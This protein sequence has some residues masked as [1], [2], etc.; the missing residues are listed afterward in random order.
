MALSELPIFMAAVR[1]SQ[2]GSY[3][4]NYGLTSGGRFGAY[5]ISGT[6]WTRWSQAV[7]LGGAE[8]RSRTAQDAVARAKM[9]QLYNR[10]TDWRLVMV[11]WL[12]GTKAADA[13]RSK[14]LGAYA[15]EAKRL[16]S[17]MRAARDQGF[18]GRAPDPSLVSQLD[19]TARDSIERGALSID[20]DYEPDL[21]VT[22]SSARPLGYTP[23]SSSPGIPSP[24]SGTELAK[25][26]TASAPEPPNP[27][28]RRRL[29]SSQMH[30]NMAAVLQGLSN[31]IKAQAQTLPEG[32]GDG[33]E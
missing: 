14:G 1:R 10:Y 7:G 2:S 16:A 8:W 12:D 17:D 5:G 20:D 24:T 13:A 9:T 15:D 32:T 31:S 6:N 30:K 11:A 22:S 33:A 21:P 27:M 3:S 4:G 26:I 28:I 23:A 29:L 19:A 25:A 18:G